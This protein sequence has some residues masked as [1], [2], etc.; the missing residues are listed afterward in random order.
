MQEAPNSGS[1]PKEERGWANPSSNRSAILSH[2]TAEKGNMYPG[3]RAVRVCLPL[4]VVGERLRRLPCGALIHIQLYA[5]CGF[6]RLI[7][8]RA[9]LAGQF[10]QCNSQSVAR[11]PGEDGLATGPPAR[12][13]GDRKI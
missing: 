7:H 9:I 4:E 12:R 10:W 2:L 6:H 13:F 5:F 1:L 8:Y 3:I 11:T